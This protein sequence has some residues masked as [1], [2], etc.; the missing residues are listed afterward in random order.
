MG[1]V[2]E[3]AYNGKEGLDMFEQSAPGYYDAI[4]MDIRMPVMDGLEAT[5]AIR[6]LARS[7]ARLVPIIAMSANAFDED[8]RKSIESGMNGHMA[9]P[10]DFDKLS[11]MLGEILFEKR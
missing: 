3:K 8:M 5:R 4:L 9:K 2:V 1:F 11:D 7:D 6:I 10:I